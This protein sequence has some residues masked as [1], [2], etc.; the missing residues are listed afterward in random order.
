MNQFV[1]VSKVIGMKQ[2][3]KAVKEG[4]VL[5]VILAEDTDES[6]KNSIVDCCNA[7]N[8]LVERVET[9][10]GLGK[11]GGIDR[12]AAVIAIIKQ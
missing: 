12:G 8:V 7:Y 3:L 9:K 2:T 4:K 6:I 5:K 10:V 11:S 1:D